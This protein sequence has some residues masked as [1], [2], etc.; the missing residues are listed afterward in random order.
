MLKKGAVVRSLAGR[1]KNRLLAVMQVRDKTVLLCDGRERPLNRPKSKNIRHVE[2]TG[3]A[4]TESELAGNK[5]LKKALG[6]MSAELN[7]NT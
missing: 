1:D 3:A 5:V 7:G 2:P 4:L 6:R